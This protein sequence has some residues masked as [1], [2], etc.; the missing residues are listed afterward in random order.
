MKL[1][2]I[3]VP[4]Y[5][6]EKYLSQ[7]L[8]SII[9]QTYNKLEIIL[10]DDGSTDGCAN[11]CDEYA[12]NDYRIRVIHKKNAGLGMARNSGL[13]IANGD[14]VVYVDSDDWLEKNM[15]E[16]LLIA[17]DQ[18]QA[19]FAVCGY[20]KQT[21]NGQVLSRNSCCTT[22]IV[23]SN[24]EIKDMV[25]LPI[26]GTTAEA[27]NDIDRE[28]CVWTNMYRMSIIKENH[29]RFV[30]ERAYLSED[31]FYNINYIMHV[32]RAVFIPECLYNYRLN[33]FSLTNVY[34]ENRFQLLC[35]LYNNE[36]DLL[37]KYELYEDAKQRV[38]R[39]FI[40]KMRNSIRIL[41]NSNNETKAKRYEDLKKILNS[42]MARTILNEYPIH[43][44]KI[45]LRIPVVFMKWRKTSLVWME[46]KVR[47]Y[48]KMR[49]QHD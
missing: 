34:R 41:V 15:V 23:F 16:K 37:K 1:V 12:K 48:I 29:L 17:I 8:D 46:Q 11:I 7:C 9:N 6:V 47:N 20:Q 19:D 14:F 35:N 39:T 28:M 49:G 36:I 13:E 26:L 40:M 18:E 3:I 42:K 24:D 30:S 25:L 38:Q 33:D 2:S 44:Y 31:L 43:K 21:S 32:K 22:K 27:R 45:S 5:N 4:I 10:V